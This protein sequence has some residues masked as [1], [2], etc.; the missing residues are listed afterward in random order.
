[1]VLIHLLKY[2]SLLVASIFFIYCQRDYL[3]SKVKNYQEE[4]SCST[5]QVNTNFGFMQCN[6]LHDIKH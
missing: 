3:G 4:F 5:I 2:L 1:M 6:Y